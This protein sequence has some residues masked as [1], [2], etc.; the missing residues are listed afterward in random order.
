MD[1]NELRSLAS[2]SPWLT[3]DSRRTLSRLASMA[4]TVPTVG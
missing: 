3:V 2:L 4:G 1:V